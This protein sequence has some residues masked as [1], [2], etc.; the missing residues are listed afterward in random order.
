MPSYKD[1]NKRFGRRKV[2]KVAKQIKKETGNE[3]VYVELLVR[4]EVKEK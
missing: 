2:N 3:P 1:L 4:L